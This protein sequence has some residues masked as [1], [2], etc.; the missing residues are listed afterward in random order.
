MKI[1]H[2]ISGNLTEIMKERLRSL[3][4]GVDT[5]LSTFEVDESDPRWPTIKNYISEWELLDITS[6][7]F[8]TDELKHSSWLEMGPT[9]HHGYPQPEDDFGYLE[10]TY[11][12]SRYCSKCGIEKKQRAPFRFKREPRWGRRHILQLNWVFDE[13]FVLPEVWESVFKP[14]DVPSSPVIDDRSGRELKSVVQL[15]IGALAEATGLANHPSEVCASCAARKY[16][17]FVRGFFPALASYPEGHMFK[18]SQYFG[19]GASAYRSVVI[20]SALWQ[21][22]CE[23]KVKGAEFVPLGQ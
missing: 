20:S 10:S 22:L 6:T 11:D 17:P 19:A 8:T 7:N 2:R 15:C 4:F 21:K 12:L 5:G 16:S 14:L 3:D 23:D 18:T 13:F 1:I 9:W